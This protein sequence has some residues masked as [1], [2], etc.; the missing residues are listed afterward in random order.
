MEDS[1]GRC[2]G[3]RELI[4]VDQKE[5]VWNATEGVP[6]MP[7]NMSPELETL[8]QLLGGDLPIGIIRSLY[9]SGESFVV[10]II[11]ML[12]AGEVRLITAGGEVPQRQWNSTLL[13]DGAHAWLSITPKGTQ[14]IA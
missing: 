14:R 10:A 2:L 13:N 9:P 7:I 11:Q 12:R 1:R 8:D 6:Y 3:L 5:C 4:R